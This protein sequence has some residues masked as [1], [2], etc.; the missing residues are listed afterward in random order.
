M[1]WRTLPEKR[2]PKYLHETREEA[3]QEALRL[4]QSQGSSVRTFV[5]FEAIMWSRV[6]ALFVPGSIPVCFLD[7]IE[8]PAIQ[9]PE[10]PRK[11]SKVKAP[12]KAKP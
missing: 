6:R 8:S 12:Q 7:P 4:G 5:V 9:I 2:R 3:E 11:K 1:K 10:R